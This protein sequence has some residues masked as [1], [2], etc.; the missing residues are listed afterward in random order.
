[1]GARGIEGLGFVFDLLFILFLIRGGKR[2]R[3]FEEAKL[4]NTYFVL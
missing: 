2:K 4:Q 3:S 1:V